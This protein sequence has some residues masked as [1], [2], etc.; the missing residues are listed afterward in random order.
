[1]MTH[2]TIQVSEVKNFAWFDTKSEAVKYAREVEAEG[3]TVFIGGK[4]AKSWATYKDIVIAAIYQNRWTG[5]GSPWVV[6]W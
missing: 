3:G 4:R 6:A 5:S 2:K 1:M